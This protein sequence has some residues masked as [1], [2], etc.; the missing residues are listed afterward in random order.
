MFFIESPGGELHYC[1]KTNKIISPLNNVLNRPDFIHY[2]IYI[3]I[4]IYFIILFIILF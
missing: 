3:E 1:I 2:M 4:F